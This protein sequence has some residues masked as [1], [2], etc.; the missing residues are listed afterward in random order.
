MTVAGQMTTGLD[1]VFIEALKLPQVERLV[2]AR[3]IIDSCTIDEPPALN[4][5]QLGE[6]L[7]ARFKAV[8]EGRMATYDASESLT[9]IR[10][11]LAQRSP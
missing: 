4:R 6:L 9:R 10:A 5:Q 1:D 3:Q 8:D 7:N 2:L 11:M